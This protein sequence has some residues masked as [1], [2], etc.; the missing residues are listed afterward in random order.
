MH[1]ALVPATP[2]AVLFRQWDTDNAVYRCHYQSGNISPWRPI[3]E[4]MVFDLIS[5]GHWLEVVAPSAGWKDLMAT[6]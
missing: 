2:S 6:A 1:V 3:T 5:K 4:Y